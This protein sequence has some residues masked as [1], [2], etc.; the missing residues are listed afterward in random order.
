MSQRR[1]QTGGRVLDARVTESKRETE[2]RDGALGSWRRTLATPFVAP[3]RDAG[4]RLLDATAGER[5][6]DVGAGSGEAL[7]SL[8]R[9]VGR[10]GRVVGV[11]LAEGAHR[12]ARATVRRSG[13]ADRVEV[14][15]G[16][17]TRLPLRA[18]SMDALFAGFALDLFEPPEIPVV[19]GE[20]R[21]VLRPR[22]RLCVVALSK[23]NAG[24]TTRLYERLRERFPQLLDR[25]PLLVREAVQRAGFHV[26]RAVDD[27][28]LGLSVESVLA[29]SP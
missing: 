28:M 20:W 11:A 3:R 29:Q 15:R 9:A 5:V 8:A 2:S 14:V 7:V 18:D 24:L 19:L 25:R 27:R 6:L 17:A 1:T 23:R 12:R 10:A 16:D 26:Q 13:V 22:G 4:L 21:R